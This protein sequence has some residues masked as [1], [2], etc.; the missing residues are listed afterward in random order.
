MNHIFCKSPVY[1]FGIETE[2]ILMCPITTDYS[3]IIEI[4]NTW[5]LIHDVL[6]NLEQ[7]S[8]W[9]F[10]FTTDAHI[11]ADQEFIRIFEY[12]RRKK[13]VEHLSTTGFIFI[14]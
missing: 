2:T 5:H 1:S 11:T 13:L 10:V 4:H 6:Q 7:T 3:N 12:F 14:P 9:D 8:Q